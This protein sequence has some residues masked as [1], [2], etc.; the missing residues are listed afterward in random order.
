MNVKGVQVQCRFLHGRA[1]TKALSLSLV[2]VNCTYRHAHTRL[3]STRTSSESR[4]TKRNCC[5]DRSFWHV[6]SACA[7]D[8]RSRKRQTHCLRFNTSAAAIRSPI[9]SYCTPLSNFIIK[10]AHVYSSTFHPPFFPFSSLLQYYLE[11]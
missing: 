4:E 9:L 5:R 10:S 11:G 3:P 8:F 1:K 6:H 7:T 2:G